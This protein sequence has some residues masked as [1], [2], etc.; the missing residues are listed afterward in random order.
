[1]ILADVAETRSKASNLL[2]ATL[3]SSIVI[4]ILLAV[5]YLIYRRVRRVVPLKA[6]LTAVVVQSTAP[7]VYDI[8]SERPDVSSGY[9]GS[10]SGGLSVVVQP[11]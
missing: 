9:S 7:R 10:G 11:P 5:L 4:V 8:S 3:C 6:S 2:V 1:M